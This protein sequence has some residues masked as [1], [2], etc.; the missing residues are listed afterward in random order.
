MPNHL[1]FT[2]AQILGLSSR[3]YVDYAMMDVGVVGYGKICTCKTQNKHAGCCGTHFC[4]QLLS[5]WSSNRA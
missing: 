1:V 5:I 4:R 3:Y 2:C